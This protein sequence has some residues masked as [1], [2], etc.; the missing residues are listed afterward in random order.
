M[1]ES[2]REA[3]EG[4]ADAWATWARA[5]GHDAFWHHTWPELA[6]FLPDP[7]E[8]TLDLG[9]GE[10]RLGRELTRRGHHVV[11]FDSSPTMV[12]Y[13]VT[14]DQPVPTVL[15]DIAHLPVRAGVADLAIGCMSFQDVDDLP[16]A[17]RDAA[18]ALRPGGRLCLAI[19]HPLNSAGAF[20]DDSPDAPFVIR[21][22]YL[23]EFRY[24]G[25][26]ERDG[27]VMTFHSAHRPLETY[28]RAFEEAGLLLEALREPA[29]DG[30]SEKVRFQ[31]WRR[32]PL[33]CFLRARKP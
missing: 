8:L 11:G 21:G 17:V 16:G 1:T 31:G 15:A 22:S 29:F 19:V 6:A 28:V 27:Y 4:Q 10:G 14:H 2:L 33:F 25:T 12:R 9:C 20:A 7:G 23:D 32:L 18:A 24:T 26:F 3:W 30:P 5:P 13:A